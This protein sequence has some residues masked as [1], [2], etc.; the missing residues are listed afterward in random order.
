MLF[1][2]LATVALAAIPAFAAPTAVNG[3]VAGGNSTTTVC[4]KPGVRKEW[5]QLTKPEKTAWVKAVNVSSAFVLRK[6]PL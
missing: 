6:V 4:T 2:S 3:T 1:T 5:R